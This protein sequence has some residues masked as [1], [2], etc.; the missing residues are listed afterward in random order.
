MGLNPYSGLPGHMVS[1]HRNGKP[2]QGKKQAN[3]VEGR[4]A[5]VVHRGMIVDEMD[6][7]GINPQVE[8]NMEHDG[9]GKYMSYSDDEYQDAEEGSPG[10]R[11]PT[12][13]HRK[14]ATH[15]EALD[16]E[17]R[18]DQKHSLG[19]YHPDRITLGKKVQKTEDDWEETGRDME[20]FIATNGSDTSHTLSRM[21]SLTPAEEAELQERLKEVDQQASQI[22]G[23]HN[24]FR[25]LTF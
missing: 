18:Y 13:T 23:D 7:Q 10:P 22:W 12:R 5:N 2:W 1:S 15:Q 25:E 11:Q 20:T 21:S 9:I 14:V 3:V 16:A 17:D 24:F 6:A 8:E 19:K 4:E